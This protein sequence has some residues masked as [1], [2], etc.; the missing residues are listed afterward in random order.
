VTKIN[1]RR[2]NRKPVNRRHGRYHNGHANPD[3]KQHAQGV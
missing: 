3:N 2:K 1:H